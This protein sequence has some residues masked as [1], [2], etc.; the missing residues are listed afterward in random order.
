LDEMISCLDEPPPKVNHLYQFLL[1][2]WVGQA[3]YKVMLAGE[4]ADEILGGYTKYVPMYVATLLEEKRHECLE[5]FLKGAR[6]L[7]GKTPEQILQAAQQFLKT[8]LG[9]RRVQQ[10]VYGESFLTSHYR[11][12]NELAFPPFEYPELSKIKGP[13]ALY[14]EMRDRFRMDMGMVLKIEDRNGM[15]R[16]SEVR[17][18]FLDHVLVETAYRFPQHHYMLNGRNKAPFRDAVKHILT[19]EVLNMKKKLRRPGSERH[20]VYENLTNYIRDFFNTQTF[21]QSEIWNP[22][23]P[24]MF[25]ADLAARDFHRSFVWFRFYA[26]SRWMELCT[27][28]H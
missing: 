21:K 20:V 25:E 15:C 23:L 11:Y 3:G 13:N 9:A 28:V 4:G 7:T 10:N 16:S 22:Q 6:E 26:L 17:S 2:K 5:S 18:P 27:S 14:K 12:N 19:P 1:R 24:Q 8:G